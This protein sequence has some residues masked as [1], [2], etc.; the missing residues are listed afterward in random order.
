MDIPIL[1]QLKVSD[2]EKRLTIR[3]VSNLYNVY[4]NELFTKENVDRLYEEWV[5][6]A[7]RIQKGQPM[8]DRESGDED[9]F[10]SIRDLYILQLKLLGLYEL[11]FRKMFKKHQFERALDSIYQI[12][13]GA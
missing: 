12:A 7:T 13:I 10:E 2:E 8:L 3:K 5:S 1:Q 4:T 11:C 6:I 9:Y